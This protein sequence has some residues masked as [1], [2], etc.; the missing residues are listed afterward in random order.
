MGRR[1][2]FIDKKSATTYSLL[3]NDADETGDDE[4]P[5]RA[6]RDAGPAT[7]K[8]DHRAIIAELQG[9]QDEASVVQISEE[10]RR[11][12]VDFGFPDDGYDYLK[13]LKGS[14]DDSQ[15]LKD[16]LSSSGRKRRPS[17][18]TERIRSGDIRHITPL[19]VHCA[20]R[21]SS[22]RPNDVL[23]GPLCRATARGCKGHRC[24]AFATPTASHRR[25]KA[26]ERRSTI[27]KGCFSA[28]PDMMKGGST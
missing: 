9:W 19:T 2:P 22:L 14:T 13:H 25:G 26:A 12:I 23:T 18:L 16:D 17:W 15:G 28:Y 8:S 3:Y 21:A 4:A 20:R 27:S 5:G 10:R 24:K 6:S 7:S 11:E 1:K